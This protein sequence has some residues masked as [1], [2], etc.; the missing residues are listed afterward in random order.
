M[1]AG[2]DTVLLVDD[3][4]AALD[5]VLALLTSHGYEAI[6]ANSGQ[7]ALVLLRDRAIRPRLIVLDL[8]MPEMD[9]WKFRAELLCDPELAPIPV[10]LLSAAGGPAVRAAAEAMRAAAAL[11]KPV[12]PDELL[13]VVATITHPE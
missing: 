4:E 6:G 13:R 11:V 7:T 12:D 9:G 3:E 1:S 8:H 2:R 10:V 5:S